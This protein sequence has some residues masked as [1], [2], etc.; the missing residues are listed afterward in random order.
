M[1]PGAEY[2]AVQKLVERAT[3][4]LAAQRWA[5]APERAL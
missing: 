3:E 5:D 4:K 1:K 2:E